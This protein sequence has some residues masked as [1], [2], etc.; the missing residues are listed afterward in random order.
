MLFHQIES[1]LERKMLKFVFRILSI[2]IDL[3]I[4]KKISAKKKW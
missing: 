3:E 2:K 1:K 4:N